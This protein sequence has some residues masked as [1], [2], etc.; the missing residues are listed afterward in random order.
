VLAFAR[1]VAR[2]S[3]LPVLATGADGRQLHIAYDTGTRQYAVTRN[4][5][6][7]AHRWTT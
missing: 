6:E 5:G 4:T 2:E 7:R 3:G 1:L